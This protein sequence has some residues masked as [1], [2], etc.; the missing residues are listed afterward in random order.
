[1]KAAGFLPPAPPVATTH[2]HSLLCFAKGG[3]VATNLCRLSVLSV[4]MLQ[5]MQSKA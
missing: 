4:G 3:L 5:S 1:M 2:G